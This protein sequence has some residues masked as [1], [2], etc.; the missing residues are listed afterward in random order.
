MLS[1]FKN[2]PLIKYYSIKIHPNLNISA[3]S[4]AKMIRIGLEM[5]SQ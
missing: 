3:S 1:P 4:G 5:I 2:I